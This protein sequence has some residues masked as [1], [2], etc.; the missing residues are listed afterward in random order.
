MSNVNDEGHVT[1]DTE[2]IAHARAI[3]A[4]LRGH[5]P[6][7][8]LSCPCG[9]D[10]VAGAVD[11]PNCLRHVRSFGDRYRQAV[12]VERRAQGRRGVA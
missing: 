4:I 1:P 2:V 8:R 12:E 6:A 3:L 11:D 5:R 7:A 9:C 10:S